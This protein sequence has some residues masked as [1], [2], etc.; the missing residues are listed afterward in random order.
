MPLRHHRRTILIPFAMLTLGAG[1]WFSPFRATTQATNTVTTV[2]AAGFEA[3]AVAPEAIVAG[4]GAKLAT[5]TA[6]AP[7]VPGSLPTELGGTT[8]EVN[9]RRAG[10]FFVSPTQVNYLIPAATEAGTANVV[11]RAGDGTVSQGTV[12]VSTVAPALFTA[13]NDGQGVPAAVL[14]RVK[15]NGEQVTEP[16]AQFNAATGLFTSRP[17]D[18][19]PAGEKVFLVLFLTGLRRAADPNGDGDLTENVRLLLGGSEIAPAF[20]GAQ[21]NF[22]GLDQINVELPR[23]L[24]GRGVV[25]LAVTATGT[26]PSNLVQVEIAAPAGTAAPQVIG[27]A[28]APATAGQP[29]TITGSGFSAATANNVVRVGGAEA[30]VVTATP[31]QLSVVVP[32]GAESGPV[33]VRTAGG[34]GLSGSPIQVRTSISGFVENTARQALIGVRVRMSSTGQETMTNSDGSFVL[35]DVPAGAALIEVDGNSLPANP[36]FPR[37]TLKTTVR[38]NRDNQFLRPIAMQQSTGPGGLVGTGALTSIATDPEAVVSATNGIIMTGNYVCDVPNNATARFPNGATSGNVFLTPLLDARSPFELPRGFFSGAVMQLTPFNIQIRPGG[39]LGFPN[40]D[41]F[42]PNTAAK[43]FRYDSTEGRFIEVPGGAM[44]APNGQSLMT[45]F[46]VMELTNYYF[47]AVQRPLTTILGRVLDRDGVT[48]L[49]NALIRLRGQEA[50][51][52][53]NGGFVLR[54]VPANDGERLTLEISFQRPSG[55]IERTGIGGI[56]A[57]AGGVTKIGRDIVFENRAPFLTV[58]AGQSVVQGRELVFTVSASDPDADQTLT[59]TATELPR[60]ATFTQTGPNS[61]QFR[62]RTTSDDGGKVVRARFKVADNGNPPLSD[63]GLV[64]ITVRYE[65]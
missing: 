14:L 10:L 58:P 45:P 56:I 40:P 64:Q 53:G 62:W 49:R 33:S 3:A 11:V 61:G 7:S 63:E 37:I 36:P 17:I 24:A 28:G 32:F 55:R 60:N 9:S 30:Q 25:S 21:P 29:L 34:E 35:A 65:D 41:N 19:G 47:A 23:E 15:T 26:A 38:A 22:A 46:G 54:F 4:F 18:L 42:P 31:T 20:A 2:S 44:V 51:T 43:L 52:D 13:N 1:V 57:V 6:Q 39:R 27:F 16:V 50:L 5:Q 48:P 59:F 12:Q 8:V